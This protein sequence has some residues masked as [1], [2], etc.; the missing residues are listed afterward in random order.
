M[1]SYAHSIGMTPA[2]TVPPITGGYA[3]TAPNQ[4]PVRLLPPTVPPCLR[5]RRNPLPLPCVPEVALAE[6]KGALVSLHMPGPRGATQ[7][8]PRAVQSSVEEVEKVWRRVWRWLTS[9]TSLQQLHPG[10]PV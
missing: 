6:A 9:R 3:L 4:L 1:H 10:Y 8:A 2:C 5:G 7:A